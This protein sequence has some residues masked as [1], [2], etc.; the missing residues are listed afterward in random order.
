MVLRLR[1]WITLE[2]SLSLPTILS[3]SPAFAFSVKLVQYESR[4]FLFVLC[5]SLLP[6]FAVSFFLVFSVFLSSPEKMFCRNGKVAAPPGIKPSSSLSSSLS[7]LA[8][9]SSFNSDSMASICSSVIPIFSIK[10]LT[11]L[12][13]ISLAQTRHRPCVSFE[14]TVCDI[15]TTA[16]RL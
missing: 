6:L 11:G 3:I 15:K 1:I 7:S 13:P 2:I 5:F 14:S 10:S 8:A 12:I 9:I 16:G 4:C